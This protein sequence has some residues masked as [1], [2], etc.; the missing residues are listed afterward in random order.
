MPLSRGRQSDAGTM[1]APVTVRSVTGM[2]G[3][4]FSTTQPTAGQ[5]APPA[6]LPAPAAEPAAPASPAAVPAGAEAVISVRDLRIRYGQHEALAGL[7]FEVRRGE[8]FALLGPNGAGKTSTVEILEGYRRR[9]GGQVSVLG[10]DPWQAGPAWRAQI[11]VML[12]ETGPEPD[13]TVTECLRLYAGYYPDPWPATDLLELTGLDAHAGRKV[14]QLSGGQRRKLDLTLAL[15][16]RPRVLFLDEPTTG[17]DPAARRD[18]WEI[19]AALKDT[20]TTMILTTHYMEEAERLADRVAVIA[21]GTLVSQGSPGS[22]VTR[23]ATATITFTLP[24]GLT[25][26]DLPGPTRAAA[27]PAH[28]GK[29]AL[30][31]ASPL[32]MLRILADWAERAGHDLADL[33]VRRPTLEDVY[34]QLTTDQE[35]QAAS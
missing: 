15:T 32:P 6:R 30:A 35:A 8:L 29:L 23:Q 1:A 22:L 28:G 12:Q 13:L 2:N 31:A 19:I 4:R 18:A 9:T 3:H 17:F 27:S 11:G 26:D 5:P 20:G 21:G 7:S 10:T 33:E 24:P 25:A 16:G 34:L 14:T